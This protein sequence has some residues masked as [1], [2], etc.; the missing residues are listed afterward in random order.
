MKTSVSGGLR[1]FMINNPQC[2]RADLFTI[3][4]VT[5]QVLRT[6]TAQYDIPFGGNT[7]KAG[8]QLNNGAWR[9]GRITTMLGLAT[10]KMD[11]TVVADS[12]VL[13]PGLNLPILQAA[14]LGLLDGATVR[15][16]TLYMA[17][18]GDTSNGTEIKFIGEIANTDELDR[19]HAKFTVAAL[20][21]RLDTQ[22][23]KRLIQPGCSNTLF[24]PQCTLVKGSFANPKT[25]AAGSTASLLIP[26]VA[27]SQADGYFSLGQVAITSGQNSGL[28]ATCKLH[29]GGQLQLQVPLPLPFAVG[30]TFTAYPG[31]DKLLTTCQTKF[32]SDNS[33]HFEGETFVPVPETAI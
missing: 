4:L 19:S 32:G 15:C 1:T 30:D 25:S 2:H 29:L 14:H 23:P 18:P 17:T 16:E 8:S 33:A 21:F 13:F 24:D 20:T 22:L 26:T 3:T 9:R 6:T 11:L 28:V 7:F 31:C 10:S 27:F 12:T 5:G